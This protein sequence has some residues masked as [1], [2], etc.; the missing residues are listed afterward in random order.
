[1]GQIRD[2]RILVTA[3]DSVANF[4]NLSGAAAGTLDNEI[5]IEGTGSIGR[6]IGSSRIGLLFDAGSAQDWSSNVFYIWINCGIV[7]LL[8]TRANAGFTI[9]FCGNTVTDWFEVFA[10]GSD[11]WPKAI[12]G[13]WVQFVI[14]IEE[15][16]RI[17]VTPDSPTLGG[18][19]GTP[20]AT[21]AIR[22]VGFTGITTIMPRMVDNTW[23]DAVYRL[24]FGE[25][26]IIVEGNAGG[27]PEVDYDWDD[28]LFAADFTDPN[29]AWGTAKI[30][31]GVI[32]LNT[33]VQF[34]SNTGSP[35]VPTSPDPG[36]HKFSDTNRVIAWEEHD[37][38]TDDFYNFTIVGDNV[39]SQSF[40]AGVKSGDTGSQGWIVTAS[41]AAP[42]WSLIS[43]DLYIDNSQWLG[44]TLIHTR[45][46]DIDNPFTEMR[47]TFLID[48]QRL[49]QSR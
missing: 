29:K 22:Y 20:P 28:I 40:S 23:I 43:K 18:T 3:A 48:G 41:S 17:A 26:G 1:M 15:A 37:F 16:R 8:D 36:N 24:P 4:D 11:F 19:G 10:G 25:P 9:R 14:D 7:G 30:L 32:F 6:S 42:R 12:Q 47:N 44:S 39:N 21:S 33:P 5:F 31:D 35:E 49:V 34:G 13:G 45:I 46:I 38:I 27:S 2:N